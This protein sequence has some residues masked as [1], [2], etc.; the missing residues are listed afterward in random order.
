MRNTW[1]VF[2]YTVGVTLR[3]RSFWIFTFLM[4]LLL[5]GFNVYYS[6]QDSS[7]AANLEEET[8]EAEPVEPPVIGLVDEAGIIETMPEGIPEGMFQFYD[9]TTSAAADLE[10]GMIDQYVAIPV[11]YLASGQ[12]EV[13]SQEFQLLQEGGQ[14][15]GFNEANN[16]M[17]SRMLSYNLVGDEA[18]AGAIFN[19]TPGQ[20]ANMQALNP[21]ETEV[22]ERRALAELL[23]LVIPYIYYFIL[24]VVSGYMLQ[25]VTKEKENRT[26]EILLL[27]LRPRD[28]MVGK[29]LGL[30]S[31]AMIQLAIWLGGGLLLMDRGTQLLNVGSYTFPD[32]FIVLAVVFLLLGYFLYASIMA[33]AGAISPSAREAGQVTW[34]LIIPFIPTLMFSRTFVD[35]PEGVASIVLSLFP[36]SAPSAMITRL[37]VS[38]VPW[39]QVAVSLGG[40]AITT[41]V[42]VVLAARFFQPQNLL[43][44]AAFNWRRLA[45]GWRQ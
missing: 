16:W 42:A 1:L 8:A 6:I 12:V 9:D 10:A 41:Y 5:L 14:G 29:I 13:Y 20:L 21:P 25:S 24:I 26:V 38:E 36:L 39:W 40:L 15:V 33:A 30:S 4:P 23:A 43:S 2:K 27:S 44:Q 34:L 3:Q 7:L 31:V 17:L 11:D 35:D 37:A 32:G 45:T 22:V 19:P 18:L 28:L